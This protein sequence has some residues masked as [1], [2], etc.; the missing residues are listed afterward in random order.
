MR[1]TLVLSGVALSALVLGMAP[2]GAISI[3]IGGGGGL[4]SVDTGNADSSTGSTGGSSGGNTTEGSSGGGLLNLGNLPLVDL[5]GDADV[6]AT[7]DLNLGLGGSGDGD[8]EG[9]LLGND[10]IVNLDTGGENGVIVDLFGAEGAIADVQLGVTGEGEGLLDLGAEDGLVNL[11]TGGDDGVILDLFGEAGTVAD[12]ELG[13]DG[14]GGLLGI[15]GG[16]GA[17]VSV[18]GEDVLGINGDGN[19][20]VNVG[21]LNGNPADPEV[22]I[23]LG[24]G[25]GTG[26]VGGA[27]TSV[28]VDLFGPA[29]TDDTTTGSVT[30]TPGGP[31]T[32]GPTTSDP[33]SSGPGDTADTGDDDGTTGPGTTSPG[34][35][36][37]GTGSGPIVKP[38]PGAGGVSPV[39]P[40]AGRVASLTTGATTCFSPDE[41]QIAHLLAR[42]SYSA[43]VKA[44][45]QAAEKIQ[46][47]PINLC[48]D[49]RAQL[50]AAL[51]AD[52]N[53][54]ALQTTI[55]ADAEISAALEPAYQPDDVLAADPSGEDLTVYVY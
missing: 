27:D 32:G 50:D 23:G 2:A 17:T 36:G 54:G 15:G 22:S 43:E 12:V 37:P 25:D 33:G 49:A 1:K 52:P 7:V 39:R 6:D 31:T 29:D 21:L 9:G 34:T 47:V 4:V 48:A 35:G 40:A 51:A 28:T 38:A 46:L 16:P 41:G 24:S 30:P 3:N 10:G 20:D 13:L 42:N 53:I 45:L 5:S 8:A 44:E 18:G 19:A 11:D 55:A 14:D 26:L